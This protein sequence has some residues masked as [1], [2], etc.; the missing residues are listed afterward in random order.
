MRYAVAALVGG[1]LG[2]LAAWLTGCTVT[3]SATEKGAVV[4]LTFD[5]SGLVSTLVREDGKEK[6]R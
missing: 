3:L 4:G 6:R 5:P 1:V 2:L